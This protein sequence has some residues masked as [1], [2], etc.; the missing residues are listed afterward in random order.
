M[1]LME[2][3]RDEVESFFEIFG[4]I[5]DEVTVTPYQERGKL[6]DLDEINLTILEKYLLKNNLSKDTPI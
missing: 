1:V 3:N 2:N 4:S 6:D 5:V